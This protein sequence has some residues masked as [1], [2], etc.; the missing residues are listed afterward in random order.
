MRRNKFFMQE[1]IKSDGIRGIKQF[2]ASSTDAGIDWIRENL[3]YP[4][5]VKPEESSGSTGVTFCPSE[6][7]ARIALDA[8]LHNTDK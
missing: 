8:Q 1:Q 2:R 4:V 7:D 3:T 6:S 5:I